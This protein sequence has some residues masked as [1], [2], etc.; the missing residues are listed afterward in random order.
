VEVIIQPSATDA[1]LLAARIIA[2][3]VRRKP[4]AV[5]GLAT[6]ATLVATYAELVRMQLRDELDLRRIITFNLDEFVGLD[7]SHRCSLHRYMK[8]HLF[9][10]I[11]L[12]R[13]QVH[14]PPALASDVASACH[15]YEM[16]IAAAGGIDLQ[17]L[18]IGRDGHIGFN[19][20]TSSL[21]SRTRIKTLAASTVI[22]Q[23]AVFGNDPVPRH[24]ITMGIGTIR[25]ARHCVLV[26]TGK[27]K[28]DALA[29]AVE[30]PVT[31]MVPASALQHHPRT[32]VIVD[33][34]AG[35]NL[36]LQ[37]YYRHVF[38]HKPD[39]QKS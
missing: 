16:S 37:D 4:H 26:A 17:L 12:P 8:D 3:L 9:D 14:I 5:L 1:A 24:A 7:E 34:E 18:G 6:G 22:A 23:Q 25:D 27:H 30:G 32:T 11:G 15:E 31:A 21:A 20:P 10:P 29:R 36:T 35:A 13:T 33:E 39:W 2:D 38:A 28:A 19:E